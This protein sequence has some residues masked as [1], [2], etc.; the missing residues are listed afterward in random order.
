L[1][2]APEGSVH[3]RHGEIRELCEQF[4]ALE[5]EILAISD[6]LYSKLQL[7][8]LVET[9]RIY[10]ERQCDEHGLTLDFEDATLPRS[11][12]D[13]AALTIFRVLQEAIDNAV[14]HAR[15]S[16]LTVGL[17]ETSRGL[18][19]TVSDDGAGFDPEAAMRGTAVGLVAMRERLRIAGGTCTVTS[20]PGRGTGIVARVPL[21]TPALV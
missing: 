14:A 12:P 1:G 15:A 3:D 6:P 9:A 10:C 17:R 8:G 19:L 7:L 13:E 2:T 18:E 4:F 20:Q 16:H 21:A 11:V 5:R